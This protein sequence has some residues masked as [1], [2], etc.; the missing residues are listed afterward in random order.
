MDLV[1]SYGGSLYLLDDAI[2]TINHVNFTNGKAAWD[3]GAIYATVTN[4]ALL[5]GGL[6]YGPELG[7]FSLNTC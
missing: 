4:G 3:G 5:R 7:S 2:I 6:I 1:S